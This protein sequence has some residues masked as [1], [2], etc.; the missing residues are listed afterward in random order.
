MNCVH[1]KLEPLVTTYDRLCQSVTD[2]ML[3]NE[4]S[5]TRN[6]VDWKLLMIMDCRLCEAEPTLLAIPI[7]QP[8]RD[9]WDE[10][11]GLSE[12]IGDTRDLCLTALGFEC[13]RYGLFD[14]FDLYIND[15]DEER[16]IEI[17][18]HIVEGDIFYDDTGYLE[19]LTDFVRCT[20]G[21][22]GMSYVEVYLFKNEWLGSLYVQAQKLHLTNTPS[23]V[24]M[25][26]AL[27]GAFNGNGVL[28]GQAEY[29]ILDG[30]FFA[31]VTLYEEEDVT[32]SVYW[33][34]IPPLMVRYAYEAIAYAKELEQ[35]IIKETEKTA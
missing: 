33:C 2:G 19:S 32:A 34:D 1:K 3:W 16:T 35:E 7:E 10:F 13:D 5:F 29:G 17:L 24:K 15:D 11:F 26:Q 31:Y 9:I 25:M 20:E 23:Y 22:A 28:D 4:D 18:N 21:C 30:V 8:I 12:M 14:E 6:L 27:A